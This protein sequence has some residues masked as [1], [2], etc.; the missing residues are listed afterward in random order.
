LSWGISAVVGGSLVATFGLGLITS[1]L[2]WPDAPV[3]AGVD[4]SVDAGNDT[5]LKTPGA[6][7]PAAS[8]STP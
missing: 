3:E 7:T 5:S 8:G 1:A 2:V 4:T 6:A